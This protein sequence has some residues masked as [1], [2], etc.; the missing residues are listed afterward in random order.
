MGRLSPIDRR[1]RLLR[2]ERKGGASCV[3]PID[4]PQVRPGPGPRGIDPDRLGGSEY[5]GPGWSQGESR[6]GPIDGAANRGRRPQD[7]APSPPLR[8]TEPQPAP[9]PT[10]AGPVD[11]TAPSPPGPANDDPEQNARAFVERNRKEAQDELKKLKEEAER[12][13]ARLGK[14]EGGIR[15]W[16]ALLRSLDNSEQIAPPVTVRPGSTNEPTS[17]EPV[18]GVRPAAPVRES[19][20]NPPK[21]AD[22]P[23][24]ET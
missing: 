11:P 20:P 17:L 18:P 4:S 5:A 22:P 7:S 6:S 23:K 2:L 8:L 9:P 21:P 15:R 19:E 1:P 12:L 13:R 14:V 16:E 24:I 10:A 3:T